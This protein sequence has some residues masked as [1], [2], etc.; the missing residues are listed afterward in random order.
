MKLSG[1]LLHRI[2]AAR[3]LQWCLPQGTHGASSKELASTSDHALH[4]LSVGRGQTEGALWSTT[5]LTHLG[6]SIP[7]PGK[8]LELPRAYL[9]ALYNLPKGKRDRNAAPQTTTALVWSVIAVL[10]VPHINYRSTTYQP[11]INHTSSQA[12]NQ[13]Q[14]TNTYSALLSK[15]SATAERSQSNQAPRQIRLL[16]LAPSLPHNN[17]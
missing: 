11:H 12:Q 16:P 2:G 1:A 6:N 8:A 10:S 3:I 5:A 14:G 7:S 15:A 9:H 4:D 17:F 13:P